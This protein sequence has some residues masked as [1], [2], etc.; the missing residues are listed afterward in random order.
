MP[1]ETSDE[2]VDL[3]TE[4]RE[5]IDELHARLPELD[6]HALFGATPG[7]EWALIR[8][9]YFRLIS[10][11]HP[12]RYFRKRLG[13]YRP[14]M[15][16]ISSRMTEAYEALSRAPRTRS[17][18]PPPPA[19]PDPA[20]EKAL[21]MLRQQ[22]EARRVE[23]RKLYAEAQHAERHGDLAGATERYRRATLL[24]PQ[25]AALKAAYERAR[26]AVATSAADAFVKQ[27][28]FEERFEHWSEAAATWQRVLDARPGDAEAQ[29]RLQRAQEKARGSS[30][31]SR[32]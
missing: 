9:A 31:G 6:D 11:F 28:E 4:L 15:E 21:A 18:S 12:D 20:K 2:E 29:A 3:P 5:R 22:L 10:E 17:P 14:K 8:R 16:A 27:A 23:A 32:A 1:P 24:A 7:A 19:P 26:A 13:A 30:G 25:D